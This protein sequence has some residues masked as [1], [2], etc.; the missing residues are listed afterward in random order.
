MPT[1]RRSADAKPSPP[2]PT[3]YQLRITL[4]KSRPPIWRRVLVEPERTLFDLHQV[5]QAVFDWDNAHLHDFE[6]A[7]KRIGDTHDPDAAGFYECDES[8][9]RLSDLKMGPGFRFTYLYDF[10]D[11]W[12]HR[13]EFQ[14][15][16]ERKPGVDYPRC[17]AG[18]MQAPPEDCGGIWGYYNLL[19]TLTD[20]DDPEHE[21]AALWLGED[22][23]DPAD[24]DH[25]YADALLG[26]CRSREAKASPPTEPD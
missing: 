23:S 19:G 9:V 3:V 1:K 10:G 17:T 25:H 5:I 21:D 16:V 24:F 4:E 22:G 12:V 26:P 2:G 15:E 18:R 13:V 7:G 20:P 11:C 6:V 14:R 8:G